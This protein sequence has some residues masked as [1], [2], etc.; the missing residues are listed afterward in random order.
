MAHLKCT[1]HRHVYSSVV[2]LV[3]Q[4]LWKN[5]HGFKNSMKMSELCCVACL[6]GLCMKKGV[7]RANSAC[8]CWWEL[9]VHVISSIQRCPGIAYIA[10]QA[11]IE[12]SIKEMLRKARQ[13]KT[14]CLIVK[15]IGCLGWNQAHD[16]PLS[17]DALL[18]TQKHNQCQA[19]QL[20]WHRVQWRGCGRFYSINQNSAGMLEY[21]LL[22]HTSYKN[23][24]T[25]TQS[26][27]RNNVHIH[28]H[29][30]KYM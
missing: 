9:H 20:Q 23:T 28:V 15:K 10:C 25:C 3:Q 5:C 2:Q 27:S 18:P 7:R 8:T 26:T 22:F 29:V 21:T 24:C 12:T 1:Q 19:I 6:W 11:P 4:L 16:T 13:H 17:R 14:T 30:A